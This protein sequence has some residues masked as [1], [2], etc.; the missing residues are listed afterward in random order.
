MGFNCFLGTADSPGKLRV[1]IWIMKPKRAAAA[2]RRFR[3][4]LLAAF[5][6]SIVLPVMAESE[7]PLEKP[8]EWTFGDKDAWQWEGAGRD[9]VLRLAKQ[10][11]FKPKVRSP[12]NLAWFQA[13][14]WESFTLT[15]EAR[16]DLFNKGNNDVCIAFGKTGDTRFYYAHLGQNADAVHLQI[17]LVDDAD[18]RA[19]TKKGAAT[20][21]WKPEKWHRIK[22]QREVKTGAIRVW[23]DDEEVLNA[24]DLTLVKGKIGLGSFDDLG[25]FRNLEITRD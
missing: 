7:N 12:F 14:E 22:L 20:L 17:H 9:A 16:L 6:A 1:M 4:C 13:A 24:T 23:F 10:S 15:V 5:A 11:D 25:S 2:A 21:P 19:I 8:D 18:R 3:A